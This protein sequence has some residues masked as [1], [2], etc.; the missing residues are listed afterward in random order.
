VNEECVGAPERSFTK[1][2]LLDDCCV[3]GGLGNT[4]RLAGLVEDASARQPGSGGSVLRNVI[5]LCDDTT[6]LEKE[7]AL[8][9]ADCPAVSI[10]AALC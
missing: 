2:M 7:R 10:G 4:G 5:L 8:R 1:Q 3:A 9:M 6:L